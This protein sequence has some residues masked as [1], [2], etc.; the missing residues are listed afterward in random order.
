MSDAAND[1][2]YWVW[3]DYHQRSAPR[4]I[5]ALARSGHVEVGGA[6]PLSQRV[7]TS[8]RGDPQPPRWSP[9]SERAQRI[10]G[11]GYAEGGASRVYALALW[12][13]HGYGERPADALELGCVLLIDEATRL[14]LASE[15]HTQTERALAMEGIQI[16]GRATGWYENAS[17]EPG[18]AGA[19]G[20]LVAAADALHGNGGAWQRM[21]QAIE[22]TAARAKAAKK[23]KAA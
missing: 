1:N 7:Q 17:E 9:E 20:E 19:L 4:D 15:W 6:L 11:R 5:G 10:L 13:L 3:R 16:I 21:R 12:L 18:G 8:G 14:G 22:A 2:G 23:G